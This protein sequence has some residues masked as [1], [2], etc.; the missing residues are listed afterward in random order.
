MGQSDYLEI[1][2]EYPINMRCA[3]LFDLITFQS[4]MHF[5]TQYKWFDEPLWL[6][7]N[8]FFFFFLRQA[9]FSVIA[10]TYPVER[11]KGLRK[12]REKVDGADTFF[13]IILGSE[14]QNANSFNWIEP[15]FIRC[16]E[17]TAICAC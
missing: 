3:W 5:A 8:W 17:E 9:N 2:S 4:R 7:W 10:F 11:Y 12:N 15:I 16:I 14:N 13:V 1:V 6:S